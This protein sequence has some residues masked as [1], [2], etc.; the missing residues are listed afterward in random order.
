[1]AIIAMWDWFSDI[2][3]ILPDDLPVLRISAATLFSLIAVVSIILLYFRVRRKAI[4]IGWLI[5]M[6]WFAV[7]LA[8]I[9]ISGITLLI[10]GFP[11][12]DAPDEITPG[13]L[14]A[15]ATRSV[16]IVAGL[17]GVALLIISYRRQRTAESDVERENI[18][19]FT[20]RF[21]VASS[22]LGDAEPA[23][24][25]AGVHALALLADEAP[26]N[27]EELVQMI[28]DVL[29]SYLR[30]PYKPSVDPEEREAEGPVTYGK[31]SDSAVNAWQEVRSTV[32]RVIGSRLRED[33]RWRGKSF[34]F[35]GVVFSG[36]DLHGAVFSGG[37]VSFARAVFREGQISFSGALFSG[38]E[39][40]FRG[41][42]FAGG[43]LDFDGATISDGDIRFSDVE[44][45]DGLISFREVGFSG[46]C[47]DFV[48]SKISGG[49]VDFHKAR[50][51]GGNL[52]L[53]RS[54]LSGG[55]ILFSSTEFWGGEVDFTSAQFLKGTLD[56]RQAVVC[57]GKIALCKA[58][59]SGGRFHFQSMI[60][61][62]GEVDFRESEFT[63]GSVNSSEMEIWGGKLDFSNCIFSGSKV[64]FESM[65]I[66]G[67]DFVFRESKFQAED[68]R[69][70]GALFEGGKMDLCGVE[71][72]EGGLDFQEVRFAGS[73]VLL[74]VSKTGSA[75]CVEEMIGNSLFQGGEVYLSS[76]EKR[77]EG[78]LTWYSY[79]SG[80]EVFYWSLD[81][82]SEKCAT[83]TSFIQL[84]GKGW[85]PD[86][87]LQILILL[88]Y[89]LSRSRGSVGAKNH[90]NVPAGET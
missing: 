19:L 14:D 49:Q 26:D 87:P 66:F 69:F 16:A 25:M 10:L 90:E 15:I 77:G 8:I 17:G 61:R 76:R 30:M 32:L 78:W 33:T 38:S 3:E 27:R 13:A 28:I 67:G 51:S 53:G 4:W 41:A 5:L 75:V 68:L 81:G 37:R 21:S 64:S 71:I 18:K 70:K 42:R 63:S 23:I 82:S 56:F 45:S 55:R 22:Q 11:A 58:E 6:A 7:I 73:A 62:S 88:P 34:D 36:G 86:D 52:D 20:D 2:A 83:S 79:F 47:I 1:M 35:S 9:V 39:V 89:W 29:C 80:G 12:L 60:V 85:Q 65:K 43:G 46:G 31:K 54:E 24:Q 84:P 44:F 48:G 57:G 50:L 72:F 40:D 74:F 59:V